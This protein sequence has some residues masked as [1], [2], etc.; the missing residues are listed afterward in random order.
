MVTIPV[1]YLIAG[2]PSGDAIGARF[3]KALKAETKGNIEFVGL[4]G[5]AM[6]AEGLESLFPIEELSV[7]GIVEILPHARKILRRIREVAADIKRCHPDAVVTID[8]P[9]FCVR[10]IKR[11][12]AIQ[13]PKVHF[14]APTVWAWRPWRVH[15]FK[16]YY[17]HLLA[18]LPFEPPYFEKVGLAC[19]FV[20]HPVL[21]YGAHQANGAAFRSRHHIPLNRQVVCVLP[22]SRRGEV[23][24]HIEIFA[25]ALR[26]HAQDHAPFD[27]VIPTL[28][29]VSDIVRSSAVDWPIRPRIIEGPAE[30]YDAMRAS[31]IALAAS[32]TVALELALA[33]VPTVVAY[34][35]NRFTAFLVKRLIKVEFVNIL[36]ILAGKSIVPEQL[37]DAC[38]AP[39]LAAQLD[40]LQGRDGD[41]QIAELQPFIRQLGHGDKLP[42]AAAADYLLN[43]VLDKAQT[44]KDRPE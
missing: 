7:M 14:V 44:K 22:G 2:E 29:S 12:A 3:M 18:I 6:Q 8:S 30:K 37:Q 1:I 24:R 25:A 39:L 31:N 35:I 36:N 27:I 38:T 11:I 40:R 5:T 13:I 28:P 16:R 42:S 32:G 15:K 34:R 41:R 43:V 10:V 17:D 20:G 23:E 33:G 26:L 4:G 21:E 9:S 19:A